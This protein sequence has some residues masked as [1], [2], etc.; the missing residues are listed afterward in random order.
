M[1]RARARTPGDGPW[2]RHSSAHKHLN[3]KLPPS[4]IQVLQVAVE[5]DF[6][7][8]YP[9]WRPVLVAIEPPALE[10]HH[11]A[12]SEMETTARVDQHGPL[13]RLPFEIR[14][15][16]WEMTFPPGPRIFK[17]IHDPK[18]SSISLFPIS[19]LSM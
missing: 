3:T 11:T 17:I 6:F 2:R 13:F 1:T 14:F 5:F 12:F 7:V 15:M 9:N 16:I 10:D 4:N 18:S 19:R 8:R